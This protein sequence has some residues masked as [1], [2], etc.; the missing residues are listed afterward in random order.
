MI[1]EINTLNTEIDT[2]FNN[3]LSTISSIENNFN[4]SISSTIN[5]ALNKKIESN[6]LLNLLFPVGSCYMTKNNVAPT[7]GGTWELIDKN[8]T[9]LNSND[10]SFFTSNSTNVTSYAIAVVRGG[11]SIR[12]R[13]NINNKVA[14]TDDT[15]EL[16]TLNFAK[17]GIE[18]SH[19]QLQMTGYTDGGNSAPI[20]YLTTAGVVNSLDSI[21]LDSIAAGNSIYYD[22]TIPIRQIY[23]LDNFCNQFTWKRT[24]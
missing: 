10:S 15:I 23:M 2:T 16:G 20:A 24:A 7:I 3:H 19:V 14:L 11:K 17:I 8:F 1:T 5:P 9:P 12:V 18:R 4:S 13:L 6:E 21:G 22:F